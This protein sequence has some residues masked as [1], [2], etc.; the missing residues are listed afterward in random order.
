[1]KPPDF[2]FFIVEVQTIRI[3][4]QPDFFIHLNF[5]DAHHFNSEFQLIQVG[6]NGRICPGRQHG[7]GAELNR[8]V[9]GSVEMLI[10]SG[11]TATTTSP[12]A[13]YVVTGISNLP[14]ST[15]LF[16]LYHTVHQIDF[17]VANEIRNKQIGREM[18][19]AVRGIQLL[20]DA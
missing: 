9:S 14:R 4:L 2:H 12:V 19:N 8:P 3:K 5:T 10:S 1:M 7:I 11:R 18:V 6:N 13:L 15:R 17:G 20:D 16:A